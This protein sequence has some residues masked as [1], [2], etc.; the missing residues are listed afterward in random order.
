[1]LHEHL[2]RGLSASDLRGYAGDAVL[3]WGDEADFKH[4]LPRIMEITVT[5]GG[6]NWDRK[7][8][9][10]WPDTETIFSRLAYSK[11]SEWPE[12]ER[13]AIAYFLRAF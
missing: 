8:W 3:V 6:S 10:E 13:E 12:A 9:I 1:M 2:L 4:F 7:G 5:E 11:W